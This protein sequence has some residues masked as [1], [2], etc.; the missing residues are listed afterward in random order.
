MKIEEI[1]IPMKIVLTAGAAQ[2]T[3]G[4][5]PVHPSQKALTTNMRDPII[6]L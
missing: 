3:D 6:A 1:A 5:Y 4:L 2:L